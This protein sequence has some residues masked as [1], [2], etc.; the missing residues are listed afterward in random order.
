MQPQN[1]RGRRF[2]V[3]DKVFALSL[4]KQSGKAY[5][6]LSKVFALPS[7]KSIT[8]LLKKGTF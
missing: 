6:T 1:P 5:L 3:D 2:T 4:Y 7:R 8:D